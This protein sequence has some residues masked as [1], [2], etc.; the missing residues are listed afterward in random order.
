MD[1]STTIATLL[2]GTECKLLLDNSATESFIS[3]QYCL[4]N[5]SL[6]GL[7]KFSSKVKVIHVGNGESVNILFIIPVIITIL[8]HTF[9]IYT[10]GFEIHD[11]VDLVLEVK[12]LVDWKQK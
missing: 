11:N 2:D 5:K 1:H 4:R 8:D 10:M 12:D 6:H 3:K 9:Q 7:P